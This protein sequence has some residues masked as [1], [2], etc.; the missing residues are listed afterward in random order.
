MT[1][2]KSTP[3]Q[4]YFILLAGIAAVSFAAIFVRFA[5]AEGIPTP[6]IAAGRLTLSAL[7]LTP[8]ALRGHG[9]DLKRLTRGDFGLAAVSGLLLAIHFGTW[10]AS[11]AYTTVLI[12]VVFVA[13]SPLWVALLE[14]V[15]LRAKLAALVVIGLMIA[16]I[17]GLVIGLGGETG[18][19][20]TR[21]A[22]TGGLLALVGAVAIALY[23]VIGRKLRA[24]L[25]LVP[26]IWLVYGFAAVFLL[27]VVLVTRTSMVG[28][29]A[30]GYFW[31]ALLALVPQ[32]I[33]HGSFNFALRYLSATYISLATQMEPIGSAIAAFFLLNEKPTAPQI[34]GSAGILLGVILATLGQ[35]ARDNPDAKARKREGEA[36]SL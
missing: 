34:V 6:A 20:F 3:P 27:L 29:S 32:L 23:L 9:D 18:T 5:L 19:V 12:S 24:K 25:P 36:S 11:L 35:Q 30:P 16:F 10:I 8:L 21:E 28:Y 4:V 26:Y 17:G 22:L 14:V 15:F 1:D 7:I 13:T 31:I 33:G 2:H